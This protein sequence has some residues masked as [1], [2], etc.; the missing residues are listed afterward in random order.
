MMVASGSLQMNPKLAVPEQ[1]S[2]APGVSAPIQP[3]RWS[4][5]WGTVFSFDRAKVTPWVALRNAVGF[6]L[7]LFVGITSEIVPASVVVATGALNVSY[8]DSGE[9]YVQRARRMLAASVLVGLAIFI[10]TR[11]GRHSLFIVP[12]TGAWAF[13]AGMLVSLSTTAA[14]LGVISLITLIVYSAAPQ[15]PER[16][17]FAG[18]LGSTGG[19]LQMLLALALW[20]IHR[21][22]PERRALGELFLELA[23]AV[24][25]RPEAWQSPP[26][27]AECTRAQMSLASLSHGRSIESERYR[28]LLSQSERMRVRIVTLGHLRAGLRRERPSRLEGD[29]LDHFLAAASRLLLAIGNSLISGQPVHAA[30]DVLQQVQTFADDM[31]QWNPAR[32]VAATAL[33]GDAARQM[34]AL[35]GQLRAA[36]DL[37]S[38]LTPAGLEAF[39]RRESQKPWNLRLAG[40]FSTLRA[41]VSL[42]S[43][44]C[45]HAIRLAVCVTIGDAL[46]RGLG[47]PRGY[48]MP[49]IIAGSLKPDFTATFSRGALRIMG[50]LGGLLVATGLLHFLARG[51]PAQIALCGVM[52]FAMRCFGSANFGIFTTAGTALVVILLTLTGLP[53][54]TVITA[55]AVNTIAGGAVALLAYW[56]W[57]TWERS[58]LNEAMVRMIEAYRDYFHVLRLSYLN[59]NRS[60]SAEL[61][62][63]RLSGRLARTNLEAAV[64]RAVAEPGGTSE[65]ISS[66]SAVLASTHRLTH[67]LMALESGLSTSPPVPARKAFPIFADAVEQTFQALAGALRG[68]PLRREDLPN[69]REAQRIL[70][71][72]GDSLEERY[73]LVNFETDRITNSLDTLTEELLRKIQAVKIPPRRV[74]LDG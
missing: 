30:A 74:T 69:L 64:D 39:A 15:S 33:A 53:P 21:Y 6:L 18:L 24:V 29:I 22:V 32:S 25:A 50:T 3:N 8:S 14:D 56:L 19:A 62:R 73:A 42:E 65:A 71:E 45:R 61:D 26:A 57:P 58:H 20:P 4:Y 27:S 5:F 46:A 63:T 37:A 13:A 9:P 55:R 31:R 59:P 34:D 68:F 17:F 16:A 43:A 7:P 54:A 47:L 11:W 48:W 51:R 35:A 52:M 67:A 28:L 10:G 23:R 49:M 70:A 38:N 2:L 44:A 41:N 60:Y 72:S 36:I 66:L 40:T 1:Q 12:V